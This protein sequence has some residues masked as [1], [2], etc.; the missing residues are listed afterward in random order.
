MARIVA[1]DNLT[2]FSPKDA[3]NN[4]AGRPI[5]IVHGTGDTRI[6]V[7]HT[8]QL[9]ELAVQTGANVTVWIPEDVGH[10]E[11]EFALPDEYERRLVTFFLES[12]T[13]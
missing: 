3:I 7:H 12:L 13:D 9:A 4:A 11:A 10:V 6:D 5:Y 1:G 8:R 2:A